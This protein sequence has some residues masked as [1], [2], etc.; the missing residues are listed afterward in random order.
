MIVWVIVGIVGVNLYISTQ[1]ENISDVR[2]Y[3]IFLSCLESMEREN[4]V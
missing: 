4:G 3:K 1:S 2:L